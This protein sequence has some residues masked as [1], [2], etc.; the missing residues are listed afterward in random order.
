MQN[1][2]WKVIYCAQNPN[3]IFKVVAFQRVVGNSGSLP[4]G[5]VS[6]MASGRRSWKQGCVSQIFFLFLET[7]ATTY[8]LE[9]TANLAQVFRDLSQ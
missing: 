9:K 1:L 3:T 4:P 6:Q 2:L 8:D 7:I 5:P